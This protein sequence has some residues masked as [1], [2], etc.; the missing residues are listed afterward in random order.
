MISLQ[1][2]SATAT[3][4]QRHNA[5]NDGLARTVIPWQD[6]YQQSVIVMSKGKPQLEQNQMISWQKTI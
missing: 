2:D 4:L 1:T 5:H 6:H 3:K